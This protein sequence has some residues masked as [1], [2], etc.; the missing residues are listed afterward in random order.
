MNTKDLSKNIDKCLKSILSN[1]SLDP[2]ITFNQI[3]QLNKENIIDI[4][5]AMY[6]EMG[7]SATKSDYFGF[8]YKSMD[9]CLMLKNQI[10]LA[11]SLY[12]DNSSPM[13]K[14]KRVNSIQNESIRPG[15]QFSFDNQYNIL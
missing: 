14:S 15:S 3:D 13:K 9:D 7:D 11:N 1:Q 8:Y 4:I 5:Q 12:F 10:D 6:S 2:S